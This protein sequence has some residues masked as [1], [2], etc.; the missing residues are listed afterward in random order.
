LALYSTLRDTVLVLAD[1]IGNTDAETVAERG[2]EEAMKYVASKVLLDSL[3]SSATYT[4]VAGDDKIALFTAGG[5]NISDASSPLEPLLMFV[6]TAGDNGTPYDYRRFLDW[7]NL[8]AQPGRLRTAIFGGLTIDERPERSFTINSDDELELDPQPA[9]DKV[10][11]L[12][13][14]I[15][16][17][18]YADSG[19]PEIPARWDSILINGAV[20]YVKEQARQPEQIINP[21]D[22]FKTLDEQITRM[23]SQLRGTKA[24]PVMKIGKSYRVI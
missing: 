17:A 24:R 23:E 20:M 21:Y 14:R 19:T 10:I 16:P 8:Q 3:V 11:T 2:L 4:W 6:G 9:A 5:F 18:A 12:H 15:P 1:E 22:F 13:Y 7:K